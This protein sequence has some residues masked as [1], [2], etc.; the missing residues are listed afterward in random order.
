MAGQVSMGEDS[1]GGRVKW[2]RNKTR[3]LLREPAGNPDL[4]PGLPRRLADSPLDWATAESTLQKWA[5]AR[6]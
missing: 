4:A 2:I 5:A 3:A 6:G 1:D